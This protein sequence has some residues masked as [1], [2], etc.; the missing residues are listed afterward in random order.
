MC[1]AY[2]PALAN[3]RLFTFL[4][5]LISSYEAFHNLREYFKGFLKTLSFMKTLRIILF[6]FAFV[7]DCS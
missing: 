1:V 5:R 7:S 4:R 3:I 2:S 6:P